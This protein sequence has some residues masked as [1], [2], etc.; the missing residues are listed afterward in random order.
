MNKITMLSADEGKELIGLHREINRSG[1]L[2]RFIDTLRKN[3]SSLIKK[4]EAAKI[5]AKVRKDLKRP[6]WR[7]KHDLP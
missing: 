6:K 1:L 3:D 4:E 7:R 5:Y 2:R